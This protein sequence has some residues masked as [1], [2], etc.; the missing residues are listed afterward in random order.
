MDACPKLK[1][2]GE[3]DLEKYRLQPVGPE[4]SKAL[5]ACRAFT[6]D[7]LLVESEHDTM[8]PHQVI[9]N[10][11]E[12]CISARSL[13]YRLIEGAD[14]GLVERV[15]ASR[16]HGAPRQMVQGDRVRHQAGGTRRRRKPAPSERDFGDGAGGRLRSPALLQDRVRGA[17]SSRLPILWVVLAPCRARAFLEMLRV[18][19]VERVVARAR[20]RLESLAIEHRE[21]AV[22]V[23][24]QPLRLQPA[25]GLG[26]A[27]SPHAQ[28][29]REK[30]VGQA[31]GV[32][33]SA[34]VRHQEPARE[35]R[36]QR[37]KSAAGSG[38]RDLRRKDIE[39]SVEDFPEGRNLVGDFREPLRAASAAHGPPPW[40]SPS[41]RRS[42]HVEEHGDAEHALA[43]D[44]PDFEALAR[45]GGRDQ[46]NVGVGREIDMLDAVSRRVQ[47][48]A[49]NQLGG[50][51]GFA[52][53]RGV[54]RWQ[55]RE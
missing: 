42:L 8:I 50:F 31:E 12:A 46:G 37:M 7:V 34:I 25:R 20:Y 9:V 13:T 33:E 40:M 39:I 55:R 19:R 52:D 27:R 17:R 14:H 29:V 18:G 16:V 15:H 41:T 51:A 4:E 49:E 6:G 45:P 26:H 10:Y 36:V 30:L 5:R 23:A 3:Q 2:R 54:A 24:D 53:A 32:A 44:E 48:G 1:L 47:A 35:A 28:H 11:R 22:A 38:L 43:A 21:H